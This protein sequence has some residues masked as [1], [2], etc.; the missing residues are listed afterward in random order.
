M[1]K[2]YNLELYNGSLKALGNY[3]SNLAHSH[4]GPFCEFVIWTNLDMSE[5]D[6]MLNVMKSSR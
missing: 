4:P 1:H 6:V 5:G 3:V 2:K